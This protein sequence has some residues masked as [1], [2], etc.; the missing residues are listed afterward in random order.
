MRS[1]T[2]R[3]GR[4]LRKVKMTPIQCGGDAFC[5]PHGPKRTSRSL[6]KSRSQ[7]VGRVPM[8]SRFEPHSKPQRE[9]RTKLVPLDPQYRYASP[10]EP[11]AKRAQFHRSKVPS[12]SP[13]PPPIQEMSVSPTSP[14]PA[15]LSAVS[16]GGPSVLPPGFDKNSVPKTGTKRMAPAHANI[17]SVISG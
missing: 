2:E 1:N 8:F 13:P 6:S 11:K 10:F 14:S 3:S 16:S 12:R 7:S 15:D 17:Q 4:I 9:R 5:A